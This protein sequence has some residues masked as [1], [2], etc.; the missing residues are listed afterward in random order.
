M[1]DNWR[2]QRKAWP[3]TE[4]NEKKSRSGVDKRERVVYN[5]IRRLGKWCEG[6]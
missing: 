4:K 3:R 5:T 6:A 1:R 2:A